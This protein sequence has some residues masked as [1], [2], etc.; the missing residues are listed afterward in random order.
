MTC[1][2]GDEKKKLELQGKIKN[3]KKEV[4]DSGYIYCPEDIDRF[5]VSSEMEYFATDYTIP[6][7]KKEERVFTSTEEQEK[8]KDDFKKKVKEM[9][10]KNGGM[11][12]RSDLYKKL[13]D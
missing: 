9:I 1:K 10:N 4:F 8:E 5:C 2:K 11:I 3:A 13:Y 6:Y 7:E 12:D